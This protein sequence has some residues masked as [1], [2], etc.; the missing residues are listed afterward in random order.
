MHEFLAF[1]RSRAVEVVLLAA[2]SAALFSTVTYGF[3]VEDAL[4]HAYAVLVFLPFFLTLY[5]TAISWSP[6]TVVAGSAVFVI[7]FVL[8]AVFMGSLTGHAFQ[9]V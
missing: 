9:V 6:K 3:H 4:R 2:A 7:A 5:F 1:M 8:A